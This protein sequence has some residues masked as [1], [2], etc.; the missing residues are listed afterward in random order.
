VY[1]V[2]FDAVQRPVVDQI[3]KLLLLVLLVLS[4]NV[5][6]LEIPTLEPRLGVQVGRVANLR[7]LRW[8]IEFGRREHGNLE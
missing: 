8:S 6:L 2:G 3:S 5:F 7:V 1:E 4:I